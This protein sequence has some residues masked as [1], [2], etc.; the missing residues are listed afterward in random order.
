VTVSGTRSR[1]GDRARHVYP[2]REDTLLLL[3]FADVGAGT[4]FLEVGT[5]AGEVALAAARRGARVVATDRNPHALRLVRDRARGEGADVGLV[6]TDLARGLGRF[7]R[8][9]FNPPYLP[10]SPAERDPDRWHNLALDGGA[11]GSRV[12]DRWLEELGEHLL[13]GG[14]GFVVVSS[15]QAPV[16]RNALRA[17]WESLGGRVEVVAA[18]DLE[19]E[20]LEVWRLTRPPTAG[21]PT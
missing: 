6:R 13:P 9:V 11:D 14:E 17:H 16:S 10:T 5:G 19:G 18:R 7:D 2:P 1:P 20:R 15:L 3:R 4:S 8:V 12:T 21:L